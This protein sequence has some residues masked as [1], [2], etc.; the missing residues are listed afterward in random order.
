MTTEPRDAARALIRRSGPAALGVLLTL[1]TTS[2]SF[3]PASA[4]A[5]CVGQYLVRYPCQ[6]CSCQTPGCCGYLNTFPCGCQDRY[7]CTNGNLL[8]R[9]I[10][11]GG[12]E[13]CVSCWDGWAFDQ[14]CSWTY[15][16]NSQCDCGCNKPE[17]CDGI[18][19][20]CNGLVDEDNVCKADPGA[21]DNKKG[22]SSPFLIFKFMGH[23]LYAV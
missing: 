20:N 11:N 23:Q 6:S 16:I 12:T 19:N 9:I 17:V 3:L 22:D 10:L 4:R 13:G 5:Q 21:D 2:V 1:L 7:D 8:E 15:L 18:D 14:G